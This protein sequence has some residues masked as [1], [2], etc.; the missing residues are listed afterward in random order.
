MQVTLDIK[1]HR[2]CNGSASSKKAGLQHSCRNSASIRWVGRP[3]GGE[4]QRGGWGS[5]GRRGSHERE[6]GR[7]L[8]RGMEGSSEEGGCGAKRGGV[9]GGER[10]GGGEEERGGVAGGGT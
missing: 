9:K 7:N 5:L 6:D 3:R 4:A 1:R 10:G 2:P 8:T